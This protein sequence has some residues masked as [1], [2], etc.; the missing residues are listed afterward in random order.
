[1]EHKFFLLGS[2]AFVV[3]LRKVL[4]GK[5][6]QTFLCIKLLIYHCYR[7]QRCLVFWQQ[8]SVVSESE[9]GADVVESLDGGSV[10][11]RGELTVGDL[12]KFGRV[13]MYYG[14]RDI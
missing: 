14:E 9:I 4:L 5:H 11:K 2:C 7:H 3:L 12:G 13:V 8:F 6:L 10:I 1:M